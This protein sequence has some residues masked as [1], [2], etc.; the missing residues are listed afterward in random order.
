MPLEY[1]LNCNG[2]SIICGQ[3]EF[4]KE[5]KQKLIECGRATFAFGFDSPID[6]LP[7]E[8]EEIHF[9]GYDKHITKYPANLR[10]LHFNCQF[11]KFLHPLDNLPHALEELK[12]S[13]CYKFEHNLNNLP[14]NLKRLHIDNTNNIILDLLPQSL[15]ELV[16]CGSYHNQLNNLPSNLKKLDL[17]Y[18][19]YDY[20]LD[21]IPD[22]ITELL[23]GHLYNHIIEKIPSNLQKITLYDSYKHLHKL[24][25]YPQITII[26]DNWSA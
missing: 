25:I 3:G 19:N 21:N 1:T 24:L 4:T 13:Y 6:D 20:S 9:Y 11:N 12:L 22:S 18:C 23:I 15:E 5:I 16:I 26:I 17:K 2:N 7:N 10:T 8:V 14:P